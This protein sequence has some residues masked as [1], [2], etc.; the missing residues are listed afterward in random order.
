MLNKIST[1]LFFNLAVFITLLISGAMTA[2]HTNEFYN[3]KIRRQYSGYPFGGEGPAPYYYKTAAL[4]ATTQLIWGFVFLLVFLVTAR[5]AFKKQKRNGLLLL[6]IT[7]FLVLLQLIQGQI[8][9]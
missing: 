1:W 4:Y 7:I 9:T 3:V 8:S 6:A 2:L 5:A